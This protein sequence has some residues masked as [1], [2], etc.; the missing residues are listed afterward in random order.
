MV[1]KRY[2]VLYGGEGDENVLK[3]VSVM[4]VQLCEYTVSH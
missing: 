2:G 3:L 4:I 1:A